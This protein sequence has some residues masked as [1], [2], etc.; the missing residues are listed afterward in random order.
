MRDFK[1]DKII[2][3]ALLLLWDEVGSRRWKVTEGAM[4]QWVGQ[5]LSSRENTMEDLST[6]RLHRPYDYRQLIEAY[7]YTQRDFINL[8]DFANY[9]ASLLEALQKHFGIMLSH[10]ALSS[11]SQKVFWMFFRSTV[12]SL[13][14]ITH[15]LAGYL[16][17][18]LLHRKLEQCGE[19]GR[20]V[21]KCSKIISESNKASED[22]HREIL[23]TLFK[24]IFGEC[25][26]VVT[27]EELL[28]SGFDDSKEPDISN[29]WED[30]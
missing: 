21:D 24:E 17:A 29:Y 3:Y 19:P 15:P 11:A 20:I 12:R 14:K 28:Q 13:L 1:I 7:V 18:T 5:L 27:S 9:Y 16:D 26:R 25:D 4:K 30:W 10:E 6:A 8:P 23:Y 22:A 2:E